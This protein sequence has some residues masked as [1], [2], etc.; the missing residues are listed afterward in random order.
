MKLESLHSGSATLFSELSRVMLPDLY[1]QTPIRKARDRSHVNE[2]IKDV[3][4]SAQIPTVKS[5]NF[6]DVKN[7]IN[8]PR[9]SHDLNT[10]TVEL[11]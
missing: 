9:R 8:E 3:S 7:C 10:R 5:L 11:L 4:T 1:D 2:A 6:K